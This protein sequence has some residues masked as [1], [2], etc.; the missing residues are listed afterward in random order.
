LPE[1]GGVLWPKRLLILR[2]FAAR[3]GIPYR[4]AKKFDASPARV[5]G[6][7]AMDV[8]IVDELM[9]P[10]LAET[11]DAE[12]IS[13]AV[14]SDEEALKLPPKDAPQVVI[15]GI[16]RGHNEDLTGFRVISALRRTW[17]TFCVIY[18]AALWPGRL[19]RER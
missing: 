1:R 14:A 5:A 11:L 18:V 17:P 16:N 10:M 9:G 8:L 7:P 12:G 2:H 15:T 19:R 4:E 13:A 3:E 6:S